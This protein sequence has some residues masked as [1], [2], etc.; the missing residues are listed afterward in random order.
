MISSHCDLDLWP[1]FKKFCVRSVSLIFFE[2]GIPTFVC[3]CIFGWRSGTYLFWVTMTLTSDLVLIIIVSG[4]YLLNIIW[5]R[6][7]KFCVWMHL[8]M[9]ECLVQFMGHC[10]LDL[11]PLFLEK[12]CLGHIFYIIKCRNPIFGVWMQL[13]MVECHI[14]YLGHFDLDIWPSL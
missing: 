11:W 10:D 6:N 2:V 5:D 1:S 9:I 3:I 7:P 4:T 13:S 14:P 8:G 12:S